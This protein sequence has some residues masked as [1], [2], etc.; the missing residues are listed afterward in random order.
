MLEESMTARPCVGTA[1]GSGDALEV[2]ERQQILR[3]AKNFQAA[4]HLFAHENSDD[5]EDH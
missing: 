3:V 1:E 5:T 2:N 4:S